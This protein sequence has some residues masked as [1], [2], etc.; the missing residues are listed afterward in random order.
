MYPTRNDSQPPWL[1]F[2]RNHGHLHDF[3]ILW[4]PTPGVCYCILISDK[5]VVTPVISNI[6]KRLKDPFWSTRIS[7]SCF[8]WL[9]I[10]S[11]S[12][13]ELFKM[14]FI[15]NEIHI[16]DLIQQISPFWTCLLQFSAAKAHHLCHIWWLS[17]NLLLFFFAPQL[18]HTCQANIFPQGELWSS[19]FGSPSDSIDPLVTT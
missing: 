4:I 12:W 14:T 17:I 6:S 8:I 19:T 16:T 11:L 13:F 2:C 10:S 3:V 1:F 5:S 18:Q 7:R 9:W 15:L